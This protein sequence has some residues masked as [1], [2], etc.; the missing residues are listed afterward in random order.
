MNI[1]TSTTKSVGIGAIP[2]AGVQFQSLIGPGS[3]SHIDAIMQLA[4]ERQNQI[5]VFFIFI[6]FYFI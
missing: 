1:P 5:E 2:A 6:V 4:K 3:S